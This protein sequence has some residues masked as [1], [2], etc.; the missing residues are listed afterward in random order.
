LLVHPDVF[1]R[2]RAAFEAEP[3]ALPRYEERLGGHGVDA[4]WVEPTS[5]ITRRRVLVPALAALATPVFGDFSSP[6][7]SR[8]RTDAMEGQP[9]IGILPVANFPF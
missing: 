8:V 7:Y 6:A 1:A 9:V 3:D 5:Q 4:E 2:I